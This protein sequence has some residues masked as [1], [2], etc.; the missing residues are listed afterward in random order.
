VANYIAGLITQVWLWAI[1]AIGGLLWYLVS[2]FVSNEIFKKISKLEEELKTMT[3][4][5]EA[6]KKEMDHLKSVTDNYSQTQEFIKTQL[7]QITEMQKTLLNFI[8]SNN[9]DVK[10]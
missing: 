6:Q 1:L 7:I 9:G 4:T 2:Y 3:E 5:L 10:H 8:V